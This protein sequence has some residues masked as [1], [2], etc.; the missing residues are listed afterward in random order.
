MVG[1]SCIWYKCLFCTP[2][3]DGS[4]ASLR[5]SNYEWKATHGHE[6]TTLVVSTTDMLF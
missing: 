1:P 3:Q 2:I 4:F 6:L 5:T